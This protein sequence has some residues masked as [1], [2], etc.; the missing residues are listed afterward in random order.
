MIVSDDKTK[1]H[2][3][4]ENLQNSPCQTCIKADVCMYKEKIENKVIDINELDTDD[5]LDIRI[6]CKK[7]KEKE[8]TMRGV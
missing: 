1:I 5:M 7:K 3:T 8:Y 6:Y 2:Y 4:I